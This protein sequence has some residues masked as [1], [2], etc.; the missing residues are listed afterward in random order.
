MARQSLARPAPPGVARRRVSLGSIYGRRG[1]L[2]LM[3]VPAAVLLLVF[4]V[5]PLWGV[6][7]AF[8]RYN[9]VAGLA[10]SP[11]V[12][13]AHFKEVFRRGVMAGL[14][15]NTLLI[16]SGKILLGELAGL[17]FALLV[18]EVGWRP[19]RQLVQTVATIPHFFSWVIMGALMLSILGSSGGVN[20]LLVWLGLGKVKFLADKNIFPFVLVLSDVWKEFGWSSVI[21]LAALTQID[22]HLVEAAAVDG[23]SRGAR[24]W[25]IELPIVVPTFVFLV[26]LGFGYILDAGFEQVLV[27]YNPTVYQTGDILDTYVYR[28]G[29]VNFKF[30]IATV[31]GVF[32]CVVGFVT[33]LIANWVSGK[34]AGQ[35]MF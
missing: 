29:L 18:R 1:A 28:M 17:A 21:Y 34:V 11:W 7:I 3:L 12:G 35:R 31:V 25:L 6:S 5:Y 19:Y 16:S 24:L 2:Y 9:P 33:I 10:G 4:G 30:E 22:P 20:D 27:L 15:R 26:V 8:V 32:K 14:L 23:A 13:L